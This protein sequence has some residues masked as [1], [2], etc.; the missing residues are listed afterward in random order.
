MLVIGKTKEV[1]MRIFAAHKD[2]PDDIVNPVMQ[3]LLELDRENPEHAEI[4]HLAEFGGFEKASDR[5]Y[6]GIRTLIG[7]KR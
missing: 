3:A 7:I 2:L 5:E 6:D 1:P 4:L